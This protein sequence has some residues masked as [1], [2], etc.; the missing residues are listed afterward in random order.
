M[1]ENQVWEK[2]QNGV[3]IIAEAGKNFIQSQE[4]KSVEEYLS[5]AKILADKAKWAG[6]DVIKFQTH[7]VEDEQLNF[8]IDSPHAKGLDRYKWTTRNTN[9]TP[10]ET[11]W[12]PLREYCDKIG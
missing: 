12:K 2:I 1:S 11:F 9:S 10:V 5:N 8:T 7:N 6:A 4:E 3:L